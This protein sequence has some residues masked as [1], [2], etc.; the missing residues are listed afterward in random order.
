MGFLLADNLHKHTLF[1][2]DEA[3]MISNDGLDSYSFGS[4]RLLDDLIQYVYNGEGCRLILMGDSAQLPPVSQADSPALDAETLRS[5]GLQVMGSALTQVVRQTEMSGILHNATLLRQAIDE[6]RVHDFPVIEYQA[7]PD[8]EIV[9][10]TD[11]I[12]KI[13]DAYQRDGIEETLIITRS[14]KRAN[15][16]NNGIR[17]RILD[18]EEIL[19]S[20]DLLLV[21]KNNYHWLKDE[22]ATDFIANGDIMEVRRVR[23]RY[24]M[25]GFSFADVLACF[26]DYNL[27]VELRILLDTLQAE[28]PALKKEDNDRLFFAVLED[29]EDLPTKRQRMKKIKED[30]WYNAVQVKYGYALTCH[31]AQGGQWKSVFLD[32]SY[33][34]PEYL[35]IDFYR[36]LYTAVTRSTSKLYLVN[37]VKKLLGET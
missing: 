24:D 23:K 9:T 6:D 20:G 32:L 16:F 4:G 28:S 21:A 35:G 2:V 10:G 13:E 36:W 34:P 1:I 37:P 8:I 27:E 25:Y 11:L 15:V 19:E 31:K 3:S 22:T 12:E 7:Y 14:N 33:V 29:Y 26:P 18:R 5:Y 17:N 30:P